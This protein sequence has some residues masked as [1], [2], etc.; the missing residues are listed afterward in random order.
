VSTAT[1]TE[2]SINHKI[3]IQ[4]LVAKAAAVLCFQGFLYNAF[5][6]FHARNT[7]SE[8]RSVLSLDEINSYLSQA[9]TATIM[10]SGFATLF[11]LVHYTHRELLAK[12][13]AR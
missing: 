12:K 7:I 6:L 11:L 3:M 2:P 8:Y 10:L 9:S 1:Q 5:E 4:L 13:Y